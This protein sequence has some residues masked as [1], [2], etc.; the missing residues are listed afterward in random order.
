MSRFFTLLCSVILCAGALS[1]QLAS[2]DDPRGDGTWRLVMEKS[3]FGPQPPPAGELLLKIKTNGAEFQAD[4]ISAGEVLHLVCRND[5]KETTNALPNGN[6][7][8]SRYRF[9]NG[10]LLGELNVNDGAVVAPTSVQASQVNYTDIVLS[11]NAAQTD[12][13]S[14]AYYDVFLN[15]TKVLTVDANVLSA[16]VIGL[17]PSTAY[18]LTVQARDTH[19]DASA[20]SSTVNATTPAYPAGG[21]I[22][23]VNVQLT[24]TTVTISA[25][26][27]APFGFHHVYIDAD[28]SASTGYLFSWES[29]NIGADYLIENSTLLV[30]AGTSGSFSWSSIATVNPVITGSA[31]SGLTYTWTI[32]VST[33]SGTPL[34]TTE[35]Y[36]VEG[37]GY[38]PEAYATVYTARQH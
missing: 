38:S 12:E 16:D 31:S 37:T 36:L 19:G 34:A 2:A 24:A 9:E 17:A 32:P 6:Q 14:I 30:H 10:M 18:S 22:Q 33:F 8:K 7:L 3:D 29:P 25:T 1:A 23:N 20:M 5:G 4:Q 15:G 28:N 13:Y 35:Q 11:W 26:Y 27:L 21:A